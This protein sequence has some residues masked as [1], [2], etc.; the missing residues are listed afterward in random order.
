MTDL[1]HALS[2]IATS[3]LTIDNVNAAVQLAYNLGKRH[4][5]E[6]NGPSAYV[7]DMR[8]SDDV[9]RNTVYWQHVGDWH[10]NADNGELERTWEQI[11][12]ESINKTRET[13]GL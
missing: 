7:R 13:G 3:E 12:T 11:C 10:V 9:T 2:A 1:L 6:E 8:A 4:G 5:R